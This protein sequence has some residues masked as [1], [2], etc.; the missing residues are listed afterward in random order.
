M[1]EDDTPA[2]QKLDDQVQP[3]ESWTY[4][5]EL[6]ANFGPTDDDENC[7]GVP[8]SSHHRAYKDRDTGLV[9]MLVICKPG[10]RLWYEWYFST[11]SFN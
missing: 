9:G 11:H 5:W 1:F 4:N 3:G 10:K 7:I 8:Y 2:S 6:R